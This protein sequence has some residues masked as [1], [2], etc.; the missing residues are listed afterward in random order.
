MNS[1]NTGFGEPEYSTSH[2]AR[3]PEDAAPTPG[4]G[5]PLYD[6]LEAAYTSTEPA[7]TAPATET[8]DDGAPTDTTG[9]DH[10]DQLAVVLDL[11]ARMKE[12]EDGDG[13]WN[14]GDTVDALSGWFA[15]FGIDVEA[16]EVAAAQALRAP[17]WLART[18]TASTLD[19]SSLVIHV[20]TDHASP[21]DSVRAYLSAL[22][23]G[24]GEETSAAVF[25]AADDQ[26]A[27]IVHPAA[28]PAAH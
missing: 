27:H 28:D 4:S 14:G 3:S 2:A 21:L 22:V 16:D 8:R 1:D 24:L 20:R 18:L 11:F 9:A 19:E 26:I 7:V 23:W 10:L 15:E 13:G 12:L 5:T 17:A 25:D 6:E